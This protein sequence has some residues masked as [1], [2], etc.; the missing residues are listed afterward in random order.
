MNNTVT[1]KLHTP[2]MMCAH[3][4]SN[5]KSTVSALKFVE[6]VQTDLATKT[7]TVQHGDL[8]EVN[9]IVAALDDA[10]YDAEII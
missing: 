2:E 10:G 9:A 7:V 4:E 3:C 6:S 1:T 8:L 5:I